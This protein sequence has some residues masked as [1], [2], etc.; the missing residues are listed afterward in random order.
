MDEDL[1]VQRKVHVDP[2]AK[3]DDPALLASLDL[4]SFLRIA[5]YPPGESSRYLLEKHFTTR[6]ADNR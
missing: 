5:H 1:S 6:V 2:R 3:L 4:H